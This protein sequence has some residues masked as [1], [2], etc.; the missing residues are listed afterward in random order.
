MFY[1]DF[2]NQLQLLL[3]LVI[4]SYIFL[5]GLSAGMKNPCL[6]AMGFSF[7][8]PLILGAYSF[9]AGPHNISI[10]SLYLDLAWYLLIL[11]LT[12]ISLVRSPANLFGCL[13]PVILLLPVAAIFLQTMLLELDCAR[14]MTYGVLALAAIQLIMTVACLIGKNRSYLAL[15]VGIFLMALGFTLNRS[16]IRIP[17]LVYA[18]A[19][20]GLALC[21]IYFYMNTYG[22]LK[23]ECIRTSQELDRLRNNIHAEVVRRVREIE[24][25][26]KKL[27]D[28]SNT[29]NMT[30][31]YLKPAILDIMENMVQRSPRSQFSLLMVDIDHFKAIND[32]QG[33]QI[34][35]QCIKS[36]A[37][38]IQASFRKGDIP[39]R[40]DGDAFTVILPDTSA[41]RAY[42]I[43]ERFRQTVQGRITPGITVS[44]GIAAYPEDGNSATSLI[45]AADQ[46]LSVSKKNGGNRVTCY[47]QA[48]NGS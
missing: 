39:G 11:V 13:Y 18:S 9:L 7:V 16:G 24:Q 44:V 23:V 19:A 32:S 2:Q 36:L 14:Y 22:R 27:A 17:L 20:S 30:G 41:T 3:L 35:D 40:Y 25:A 1:L 5:S 42:L 38:L 34:G 6:K 29:D 28:K 45:A 37:K 10:A 33:H 15:H 48:A 31:L 8:I 12:L 47:N 21:A 46:A 43:A 4:S 26:S